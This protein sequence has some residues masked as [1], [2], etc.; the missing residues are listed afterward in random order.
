MLSRLQNDVV[1]ATGGLCQD[2]HPRLIISLTNPSQR[3][4]CFHYSNYS[5]YSSYGTE[6]TAVQAFGLLLKLCQAA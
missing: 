6:I 3:A 1:K 2:L 4:K 5:N